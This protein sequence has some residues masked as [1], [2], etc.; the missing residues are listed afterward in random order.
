MPAAHPPFPVGADHGPKKKQ[1][2][3]SNCGGFHSFEAEATKSPLN[4]KVVSSR[5]ERK[6]FWASGLGFISLL[7]L[8]RPLGAYPQAWAVTAVVTGLL[9]HLEIF[10]FH[11]APGPGMPKA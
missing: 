3:K 9:T 7:R 5:P 4:T 11:H 1:L 6:F 2:G 8:L 10:G